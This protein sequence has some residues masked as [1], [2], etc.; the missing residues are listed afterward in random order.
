MNWLSIQRSDGTIYDAELS[1]ANEQ[2]K[3]QGRGNLLIVN[4]VTGARNTIPLHT[5]F[6]NDKGSLS[7]NHLQSLNC[8]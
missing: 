1:N 5:D 4:G 3:G 7:V 2:I 6:L 8:R